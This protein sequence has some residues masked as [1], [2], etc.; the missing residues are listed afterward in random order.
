MTSTKPGCCTS[1]DGPCA[2]APAEVASPPNLK[3]FSVDRPRAPHRRAGIGTC[4]RMMT[5]TRLRRSPSS[6]SN[7]ARPTVT[8]RPSGKHLGARIGITA[9]LHTWGSALT[10]HPHVHM[11][12]PGD[13]ISLD[14]KRKACHMGNVG[15]DSSASA[16]RRLTADYYSTLARAVASLDV[17]TN[18]VR[19]DIFECARTTLLAFL[20]SADPPFIESKI[21]AEQTALE[22]AIGRIQQRA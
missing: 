8:V 10:H 12:V 21:A 17:N 2:T 20:R 18:E 5:H 4:R 1:C 16:R 7:S 6:A 14:G 3:S 15:S 9:V 11:I 22:D 13:G 19:N